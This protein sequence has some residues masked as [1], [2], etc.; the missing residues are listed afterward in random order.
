MQREKLLNHIIASV[1]DVQVA[2]IS[3]LLPLLVSN[4]SIQQAVL[5]TVVS[6]IGNE[7][8]LQLVD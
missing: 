4:A 8:K 1:R 2:D 3:M 5:N 7:L 6:F